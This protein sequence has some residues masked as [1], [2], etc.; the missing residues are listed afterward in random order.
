MKKILI[1]GPNPICHSASTRAL[2]QYFSD[3]RR[4]E[5]FQFYSNTSTPPEQ[6][7]CSFFQMTDKDL[8]LS[9]FR[10]ELPGRVFDDVGSLPRKTDGKMNGLFSLLYRIGKTEKPIIHLARNLLWQE[11]KVFNS[12]FIEWLN[13]ANFDAVFLH[14]SNAFFILKIGFSIAKKYNVPL[15]FEIADDYFFNSHLSFSPFY[16]IYR[17]MYKTLFKRVVRESASVFYISPLM[18]EKYDSYFHVNGVSIT[19]PAQLSLPKKSVTFNDIRNISYFGNIGFKRFETIIAVSKVLAD[20]MPNAII[21]VYCPV[22]GNS[23]ASK[24]MGFKNISVHKSLPYSKMIEAV[25]AADV[26]LFVESF[27]KRVA[28]D[29]KYSLSTKVGDYLNSGRP[30]IAIGSKLAGSIDFFEKT[31]TSLC[32][33]NKNDISRLVELFS[34]YLRGFDTTRNATLASHFFNENEN[35][36]KI[37]K[38]FSEVIK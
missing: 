4:N 10:K 38:V 33:T 32:I 34:N 14:S 19:S 37:S 21:H 2:L 11:R 20:R 28:K 16:Y 23:D 1:V 31:K 22:I 5:L 8:L 9:F 24:L 18:K 35:S 3:F 17:H 25:N 7:C 6:I 13:H 15:I 36:R 27:S 12:K 29:I 30:I 26:L